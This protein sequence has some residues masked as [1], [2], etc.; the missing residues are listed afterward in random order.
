[1]IIILIVIAYESTVD[2]PFVYD[3]KLE[4]IGNTTIRFIEEWK[5][6]LLYN[7]SRMLLQL[8]YALNFHRSG[9]EP[10]DYHLTNII[11]HSCSAGACL[12]LTERL[13]SLAKISKPL[14]FASTITIVWTLHPMATESV[15]YITGR[16]ESLCALFSLLTMGFWTKDLETPHSGWKILTF[17]TLLCA[18]LSKQVGL[19]LPFVL[20]AM[21]KVFRNT[22][23]WKVHSPFA[24]LFVAGVVTRI[25]IV[26]NEQEEMNTGAFYVLQN[27]LPQEVERPFFVQIGT[28]M[29]VWLRYCAL[30]IIPYQQTI[31]HHIVDAAVPS[32]K[33]AGTAAAWATTIFLGWRCSRNNPL[34]RFAFI[35]A[36]LLLLPSS[37]F[38]PLKENM[39]EHRSHQFGLFLW[40]YLL[41]FIPHR[42]ITAIPI[43]LGLGLTVLTHQRNQ[44]WMSEITLWKEATVYSP[45]VGEAWYGLGD[46][47]RFS[48]QFENAIEAFQKCTDLDPNYLDCWNNLGICYA[49]M[50]D[51]MRAQQMWKEALLR[52]SSY[53]KAH[54]N[55]G[56]LAFLRQQWDEALLELRTAVAFCPNNSIAH[57]GLGSIY[58]GPRQNKEKAIQHFEHLLRVD[59]TFVYAADA[60]EKLL[61]LTW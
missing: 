8:S 3:D 28:Q 50:K 16:S 32:L 21:E 7:P 27:L 41:S 36:I 15:T 12:F 39:A 37:S 45:E 56:F 44:I 38:A 19:M 26:M 2:A 49:E 54:T 57:Y 25:F 34:A 18:C 29:E 43:F 24:L 46:A 10:Q 20:L 53:C 35:A 55:L 23:R 59:P 17:I 42:L 40:I 51:P 5:A 47:Y 52:D 60:R 31:Y 61:E 9:L 1:V 58:Y 14:L 4:V 11:I 48:K 13:A 33:T 30:W 6:I 22:I